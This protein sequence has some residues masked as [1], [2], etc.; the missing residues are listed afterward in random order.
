MKIDK[1]ISQQMAT[2][3]GQVK[4][5]VSEENKGPSDSVTLGGRTDDLNI[6]APPMKDVKY[7]LTSLDS[8]TET[9]DDVP[10]SGKFTFMFDT[11]GH[12]N[13][14]DIQLKASLNPETGQFDPKW[15]LGKGIPMNDDQIAGDKK[16][17][18]GIYSVTKD[19]NVADPNKQFQWYVTGDVYDGAWFQVTDDTVKDLK[20]K[21]D[22]S[23]KLNILKALKDTKPSKDELIVD[24]K[25]ANF[26]E[27]E[28]KMVLEHTLPGNKVSSGK[29]LMTENGVRT[30]EVDGPFTKQIER[31]TT[32]HLM[33][34]HKKG[35]DGISFWTWAPAVGKDDLKD[36]KL[37]V[38]VVDK[39]GKMTSSTPMMKDPIT[40]NWNLEKDTGWKELEG[41]AYR[42]SVRDKDGTI[43]KNANK[44]PVAYSDPY[45]RYLQGQQ[46]G[47]ERI[48]VDPVLGIETGWYDDSGKGGCNYADNPQWGRFAVSNRPDASK[49]QLVLMDENGKQLTKKELIDRLGEPKLINY[50]DA[51]PGDKRD[52]DTL[53][54]WKVD[55]SGKVT[56]YQWIDGVRDDGTID[57]KKTGDSWVSTV[58]NFDKLKGM[59]YELRVYDKDGKLEGDKDGDGKLSEAERRDTPFNDPV[60][61]IIA[62]R[63]GAE[64]LSL[65][66]ES[67]YK[68]KYANARRKTDDPRKY[69]IYEAHVGSFMGPKDN[70]APSTFKT[71]IDNLDYIENLAKFK[72]TD[73]VLD[74]LETLKINTKDLKD[75]LGKDMTK[76]EITDALKK[77]GLYR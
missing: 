41:M 56:K 21:F 20:N 46:R 24:L 36:Y 17:G 12:Y 59:R 48:Y 71:M 7:A 31:L 76:D 67:S 28:I 61:N 62:D 16:S 6:M 47:V 58:N 15:N 39:N 44:T 3:S 5:Q 42:Y 26:S 22:D 52:V 32:H 18:D 23:N 45:S 33:G 10:N 29:S 2:T 75:L 27:Q 57:M 69:V 30:F 8:V 50:N 9:V 11:G 60:S 25:N 14:R 38:D 73:K 74:K 68:F 43:L 63:P 72:I 51:K 1:T 55:T 64:R 65:I 35:E 54:S 53:N 19:L 49:A 66:K 70:A 4:K 34:V 40:G 77:K 37:Y 13:I